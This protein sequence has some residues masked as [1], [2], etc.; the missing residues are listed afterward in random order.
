MWQKFKC[1]EVAIKLLR[2][3]LLSKLELLLNETSK[4]S[5][6]KIAAKLQIHSLGSL[7]KLNWINEVLMHG[8]L[9][10]NFIKSWKISLVTYKKL[11]KSSRSLSQG[12]DTILKLN[13]LK[14]ALMYKMFN[15]PK[16]KSHFQSPNVR[17]NFRIKNISKSNKC[18][19]VQ[20]KRNNVL[21][22]A[23]EY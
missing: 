22:L 19:M 6:L 13:K 3:Q 9:F 5:C 4:T 1:I 14:Q 23:L 17:A 15:N 18:K 7:I 10:E 20:K 11:V 16:N 21:N 2:S 12:E 8:S